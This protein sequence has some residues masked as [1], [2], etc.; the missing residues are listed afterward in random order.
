MKNSKFKK[1][2]VMGVAGVYLFSNALATHAVESGF[3]A[4]RRRTVTP[5]RPIEGQTPFS[6][7][8]HTKTSLNHL[9]MP[10]GHVSAVYLAP[11]KDAP[12]IALIQDAHGVEEAQRNIA[13][14]IGLLASRLKIPL[15]GLEGASGSFQTEPYRDFPNPA[16]TRDLADFF[17]EKGLV[18]GPEYAALTL[19]TSPAFFGA[20]D[21]VL[22]NANIKSLKNAWTHGDEARD[23]LGSLLKRLDQ[24]K[25]KY[26]SV[27]LKTF[28]HH[29]SMFHSDQENLSDYARALAQSLPPPSMP[30]LN[31]LMEVQ[32]LER[33]IDFNRIEPERQSVMEKLMAKMSAGELH[34][35]VTETFDDRAANKGLAEGYT[36]LNKLCLDH[37]ISL[38]AY[39][40][41]ARHIKSVLLAEE[42]DPNKLWDE[43]DT[44]EHTLPFSLAKTHH[45]KRLVAL[46]QN[47]FLLQKLLNHA[48]D[49]RDWNRYKTGR[50]QIHEVSHR[51]PRCP[52]LEPFEKFC[53]FAEQR[54]AALAANLTRQMT[55]TNSRSA[56]LIA[57][58][59]HTSGLTALLFKSNISYAVVTP[60]ITRPFPHSTYF[61]AFARDSDPLEQWLASE[62]ACLSKPI[63]LAH[64]EGTTA[65]G[66]LAL[67]NVVQGVLP[68]SEVSPGQAFTNDPSLGRVIGKY[69]VAHRPVFLIK[70]Y[71]P[72][73]SKNPLLLLE[74]HVIDRNLSETG[75]A[76]VS[77]LL[78]RLP[79]IQPVE[80]PPPG[81]Y[82]MEN[83]IGR[84]RVS[85]NDDVFIISHKIASPQYHYQFGF[86]DFPMERLMV[87][88]FTRNGTEIPLPPG[89]YGVLE[90]VVHRKGKTVEWI[91]AEMRHGIPH[92]PGET[93]Y[94]AGSVLMAV[95]LKN[96]AG[97]EVPIHATL[98]MT[99]ATALFNLISKNPI[100]STPFLFRTLQRV[101]AFRI[102]ECLY[103]FFIDNQGVA[104]YTISWSGQPGSRSTLDPESTEKLARRENFDKFIDSHKGSSFL[105]DFGNTAASQG[106][107]LFVGGLL[108]LAFLQWPHLTFI[109]S[110]E[111]TGLWMGVLLGTS[112]AKGERVR[113]VINLMGLTN[114][115]INPTLNLLNTL[116]KKNQSLLILAEPQNPIF[117]GW[118]IPPEK[119]ALIVIQETVPGDPMAIVESRYWAKA[120]ALPLGKTILTYREGT[121]DLTGTDYIVT[122]FKSFTFSFYQAIQTLKF[123]L[124]NA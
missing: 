76:N 54:N 32:T 15:V 95:L 105:R 61:E 49:A 29:F 82:D 86:S 30:Q 89:P 22:Y 97:K 52:P 112:M 27:S 43:V 9:L 111:P 93:P 7:G 117:K 118:S 88:T 51:F 65:R 110:N 116:L 81:D 4:E 47:L 63:A 113:K 11:Q 84:Y 14:I 73:P 108:I 115:Q 44:I 80:T 21:D 53:S 70:N 123:T 2:L 12:F 57:G 39:P 56:I 72:A 62:R 79:D 109:A 101:P 77:F 91:D 28:D 85:V 20:E 40:Q 99:N 122:T 100:P 114:E 31:R 13:S 37:S 69:T 24:L 119:R 64:P 74:K 25:E 106:I 107:A 3:W 67:Q 10:L 5:S 71:K 92:A 23:W 26:Y 46:T 75:S 78:S 1:I 6:I 94:H 83:E 102:P 16:I 19:P 55:K 87:E 42:V 66:F 18:A 58:G 35:M 33:E 34:Q 48:L 98:A 50:A 103:S 36:R 45:E 104:Q 38:K 121:L 60:S 59:F 68:L 8:P 120:G 124:Q 17:L 90:F 41:L 96:V